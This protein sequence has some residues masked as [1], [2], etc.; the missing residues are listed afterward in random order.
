MCLPG[1]LL[2]LQQQPPANSDVVSQPL[3]GGYC[4]GSR[5]HSHSSSLRLR[6]STAFGVVWIST[7]K[8]HSRRAGTALCAL[9]WPGLPH[10]RSK[11]GSRSG[12]SL[13]VTAGFMHVCVL[14]WGR[15]QSVSVCLLASLPVLC[16]PVPS[17]NW[18]LVN[19]LRVAALVSRMH[20]D[21]IRHTANARAGPHMCLALSSVL[22][23][24]CCRTWLHLC[25]TCVLASAVVFTT[26]ITPSKSQALSHTY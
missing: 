15:V 11:C 16:V 24:S 7:A 25:F 12:L 14:W 19:K 26:N 20:V 1:W 9:F 17:C 6:V 3:R 13:R 4:R 5:F 18:M 10:C 21:S 23:M 2:Q 8:Q 22:C